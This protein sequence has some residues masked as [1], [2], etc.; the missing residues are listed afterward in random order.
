MYFYIFRAYSFDTT[1][2]FYLMRMLCKIHLLPIS[3]KIVANFVTQ[4]SLSLEL[5]SHN[6]GQASHPNVMSVQIRH[7]RLSF[8]LGQIG[9]S[10]IQGRCQP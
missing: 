7:C 10:D 5:S 4:M 9:L 2:R 3:V 1:T 6:S 8:P